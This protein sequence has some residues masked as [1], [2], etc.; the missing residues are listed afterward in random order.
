L[1]ADI[2]FFLQ[3]CNYPNECCG[4]HKLLL[5]IHIQYFQYS[6]KEIILG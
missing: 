6:I 3:I 5:S 2:N 1:F 4:V